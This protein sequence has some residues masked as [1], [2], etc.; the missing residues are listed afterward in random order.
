M[1]HLLLAVCNSSLP[2]LLKGL[3]AGV[4]LSTCIW[5]FVLVFSES[6]RNCL[7]KDSERCMESDSTARRLIEEGKNKASKNGDRI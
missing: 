3:V 4:L 5:L 2:D 1:T 7:K 6:V